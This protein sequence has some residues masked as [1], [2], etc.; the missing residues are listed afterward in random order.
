MVALAKPMRAEIEK[1]KIQSFGKILHK[2]WTL[3]KK[4]NYLKS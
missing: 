2:N 4:I 3:K 1:N